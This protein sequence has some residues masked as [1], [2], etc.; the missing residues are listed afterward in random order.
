MK[1]VIIRASDDLPGVPE[2][3][4]LRFNAVRYWSNACGELHYHGEY[5]IT[6]DELP[7]P[8][9]DAYLNLWSE[10][11]GFP[12]YLVETDDGYRI[13]FT[14]LYNE[15]IADDTGLSME[16]LFSTAIDD[17]KALN[18]FAIF[19][20]ATAYVLERTDPDGH[21][22]VIVLPLTVTG[23]S[24]KTV[25]RILDIV[26]YK[27]AELICAG[28]RINEETPKRAYTVTVAVDGRCCFEIIAG[29]LVEAKVKARDEAQSKIMNIDFGGIECID[30]SLVK[31]EDEEGNLL[32]Y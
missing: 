31:I 27:H 18:S 29:S 3:H 13:A 28:R 16:E 21:E 9:K 5:M 24:M 32:D 20:D 22:A 4:Q 6:E 25:S 8:L 2:K 17:V 26:M 1:T 14:V 10:G 12:C 30:W 7:A 11:H 15:S 19:N 23:E